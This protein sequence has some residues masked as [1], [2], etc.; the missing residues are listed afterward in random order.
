MKKEDFTEEIYNRTNFTKE[1]AKMIVDDIFNLIIE[2]LKK[3]ETVKIRNFGT[4]AVSR[5]KNGK[6]RDFKKGVMK[7]SES[8]KKIGFRLSKKLRRLDES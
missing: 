5:K 2:S 8:G 1:Q 4:F 7:D 6:V 3:K